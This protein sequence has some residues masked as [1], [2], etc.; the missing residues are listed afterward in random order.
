LWPGLL[1]AQVRGGYVQELA[2]QVMF[3]GQRLEGFEPCSCLDEAYQ[4]GFQ[5]GAMAARGGR[6]DDPAGPLPALT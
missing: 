5:A 4:A 3:L 6:S 1:N 2:W